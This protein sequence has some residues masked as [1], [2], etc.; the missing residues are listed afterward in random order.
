MK[1]WNLLYNH[2]LSV[3][4]EKLPAHLTYHHP[5]H[6]VYVTKMA[7]HI[8][9]EENVSEHDILL[10]KTAALY[11]D[12]GFIKEAGKH[13]KESERLAIAE[14]PGF[15]YSPEEVKIIVG[16]IEATTIPQQPKTKLEKILADADLE[17]FGTDDF[18]KVGD[19]LLEELRH[20]NPGLTREQWDAIQIKFLQ[21][22][23]YHTDYCLKNRKPKKDLNL[24]RLIEESNARK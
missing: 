5:D 23:H 18:K 1:D 6:T 16:L 10:L 22:H 20:D 21:Q 3:L 24:K 13:E 2:A 15:G 7:E 8:A 14:L 12:M 17:Y 11:H 19:T 4:R 9:R